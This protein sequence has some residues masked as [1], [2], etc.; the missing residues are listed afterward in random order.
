MD[1]KPLPF[2]KRGPDGVWAQKG[3]TRIVHLYGTNHDAEW[4]F[5]RL[6][7]LGRVQTPIGKVHPD[8][9]DAACQV[10]DWLHG[11]FGYT[12]IILSGHSY[13]G[14]VAELVKALLI[15]RGRRLAYL[16]TYGAIKAGVITTPQ[17]GDLST[18]YRHR[19]DYA[20]FWGLWPWYRRS[21]NHVTIGRW[22]PPVTAHRIDSY[23]SALPSVEIP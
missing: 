1:W 23:R 17:I 10:D 4:S 14:A 18:H 7:N 19:G 16:R 20:P 13:G 11:E 8:Y 2:D 21:G 15:C 22:R 6:R 12:S 9:Y 5:H 3:S